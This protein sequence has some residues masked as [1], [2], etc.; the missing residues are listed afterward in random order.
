MRKDIA[1]G[2]TWVIETGE[3]MAWVVEVGGRRFSVRGAALGAAR[4]ILLRGPRESLAMLG[5]AWS[6]SSA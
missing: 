4:D 6:P 2:D 1:V 3:S 5:N